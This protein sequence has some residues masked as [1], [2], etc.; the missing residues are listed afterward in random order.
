MGVA[1]KV[2]ALSWRCIELMVAVHLSLLESA[3][4]CKKS[5]GF[6]DELGECLTFKARRVLMCGKIL[7]DGSYMVVC[8]AGIVTKWEG[9]CVVAGGSVE[10]LDQCAS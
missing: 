9:G 6:A 2:E 3:I 10:C 8:L 4:K 5:L 7:V 1:D